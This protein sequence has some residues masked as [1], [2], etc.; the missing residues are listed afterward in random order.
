MLRSPRPRRPVLVAC[1]VL[2]TTALTG[3]G[4]SDDEQ[5]AAP[6]GT[7][8][9]TTAPAATSPAGLLDDAGAKPTTAPRGDEKQIGNREGDPALPAE[10]ANELGDPPAG[11]GKLAV[12]GDGTE[13]KWRVTA[14]VKGEEFCVDA[15][16]VGATDPPS[17]C[18]DAAIAALNLM[19]DGTG[20][21]ASVNPVQRDAAGA[22]EDVLVWG[23]VDR[24]VDEVVV[25]YGGKQVR[26]KIS[27]RSEQ[28]ELGQTSEVFGE[29][30]QEVPDELR[31]K[32]FGVAVPFA[33]GNPP[34]T[35]KAK[36]KQGS[37]STVTLVLQ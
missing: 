24:S 30:V 9:P 1:V 13:P 37:G 6:T 36:S 20:V 35:A 3:C 11:G 27:K 7:S 25:E 2:A 5:A 14:R 33:T 31:V 10:S 28:L 19:A 8:A 34:T 12:E 32:T 15:A 23:F 18:S 17:M 29:G 21:Q 16:A 4:G 26:A 22:A